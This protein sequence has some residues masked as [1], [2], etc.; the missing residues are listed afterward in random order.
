MMTSMLLKNMILTFCLLVLLSVPA[1]SQ[2]ISTDV[3]NNEKPR[4]TLTIHE[5]NFSCFQNLQCLKREDPFENS[6]LVQIN[7][8]SLTDRYTVEGTSKTN[9]SLQFIAE[10]VIS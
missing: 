10:A 1:L 4:H 8:N 5:G 7:L 2:Q 3:T 6:N 9:R